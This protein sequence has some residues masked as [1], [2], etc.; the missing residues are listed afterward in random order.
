MDCS[1][2]QRV[3][4][5]AYIHSQRAAILAAWHECVREDP[6]LTTASS[7]SHAQ[8]TDSIPRVLDAFEQAL[9]AEDGVRLTRADLEQRAGAAEHGLQRWQQGYDLRETMREWAHLHRCILLCLERYVQEQPKL[10]PHIAIEAREALVWLCGEGASE[11]AHRYTRLQQA[12]A[13]GRMRDLEVA[14]RELR[15]V[16][17]ERASMLREAAHDLRG[18]VGVITQATAVLARSTS[19]EMRSDYQRVLDRALG[20]THA[21]LADLIDLARL[22][23][24]QERVQVSEFDVAALLRELA[25]GIRAVATERGLFLKTAGPATLLVRGDRIKVQRIAQNLMLNALR[26]TVSGGV[27]LQWRAPPAKDPARWSLSIEDTGPGFEG[28]SVA[29]LAT[30]LREAT[31]KALAHE[32]GPHPGVIAP[33]TGPARVGEGIGL[34]IVKRLCELLGAAIELVS[35]RGA[36]TTFTVT[37]PLDVPSPAPGSGVSAAASGSSD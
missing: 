37:F 14:L 11:S 26:A 32:G 36:G 24:G 30:E 17:R 35:R 13:V 22:E 23:A 6:E 4:L 33:P 16:E 25:D 1:Q 10:E 3:A 8:F 5:A 18:S 7:I 20:A 12:E 15:H 27:T 19:E 31:D 21:L 28:A 34:S 2:Q 29:P 9:G